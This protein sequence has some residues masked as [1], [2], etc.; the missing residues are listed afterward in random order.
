MLVTKS[1]STYILGHI[2][3]YNGPHDYHPAIHSVVGF[4]AVRGGT[5]R[6]VKLVLVLNVWQWTTCLSCFH[7]MLWFFRGITISSSFRPLFSPSLAVLLMPFPAV[8][9]CL[10]QLGIT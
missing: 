5:E 7:A 8:D 1:T 2:Y 3:K 10:G 6:S 4:I 9:A